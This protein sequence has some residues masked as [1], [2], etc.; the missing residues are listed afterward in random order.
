MNLLTNGNRLLNAAGVCAAIA[1]LS[2]FSVSPAEAQRGGGPGMMRG[3]QLKSSLLTMEEVQQELGL[4][5][6]LVEKVAGPAGELNDSLR[7]EM[8]AISQEGGDPSEIE[9]L[10][11]E[12]REEEKE[13]I[14]H[15]DEKQQSRLNEL[16]YQRI[17]IALYQND[18]ALAALELSDEQKGSIKEIMDGSR[19]KFMNAMQEARDSGDRAAMMEAMQ[20]VNAE[21]EKSLADVL[22][23]EQRAKVE[24]LKGE[25]FEFPQRQGREGGR[26]SD[27]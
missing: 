11:K 24:E 12:M 18:E 8:R 10:L 19:E 13:I 16:F 25:A 4:S 15:L 22:N 7:S 9:E 1:A 20:K 21:I 14:A 5:E 23:D 26:R 3:A 17:G 27:F 2:F 6:E